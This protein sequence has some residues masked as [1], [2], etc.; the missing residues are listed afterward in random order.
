MA[1]PRSTEE[2]DE[3]IRRMGFRPAGPGVLFHWVTTVDDGVRAEHAGRLGTGA[4]G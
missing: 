3:I 4:V 2:Y 1:E